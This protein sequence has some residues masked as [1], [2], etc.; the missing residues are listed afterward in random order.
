MRVVVLH[1]KVSEDAGK[2][3]L[4]VLVQR[5]AV[6][7]ALVALGYDP[8][9]IP[10]SLDMQG[11]A[12]DIRSL[13]P[14]FAF[15]LVESVEGRGRLIHLAPALLDHLEIPYTGSRTEAILLTSNKLFA[16]TFLRGAGIPTPG[17]YTL[18][19][20]R[21]EATQV[22]GPL[23]VKSLWEHASIGLDEESVVRPTGPEELRRAMEK[24]REKLAGEC[25]AEAYI[26]GREF[27]LSLL[28]DGE[29]PEVLPPAE[30]RFEGYSGGKPRLV[31]YRAKWDETS[32]EYQHTRRSF[33]FLGEDEALLGKLARL[34]GE[35]WRLF[36]LRGYARVDFRVDEEGRPW[37][38]EVNANPCLSPDAGFTAAAERAGLT[39]SQVISRIVTAIERSNRRTQGAR[40]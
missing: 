2:D 23:I 26:D 15:N 38:L 3:E 19:D 4:D 25:F 39:Y 18:K 1:G 11:V 30:I 36:D 20:L 27:N 22:S 17:W 16:K 9:A 37:V 12:R 33:D 13:R 6:A 40:M 31:G 29:E 24:R 10:F 5:D 35:C 8:V 21:G 32:F 34:A 14:A 7:K 28:A